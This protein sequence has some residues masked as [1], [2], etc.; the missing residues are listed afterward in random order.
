[1]D[2][3]IVAPYNKKRIDLVKNL[4]SKHK[5][6]LLSNSSRDNDK[7]VFSSEFARYFD[8][9]SLSHMNTEKKPSK[10][11]FLRL[12][13]DFNVYTEEVIFIDDK[14]KNVEGAKK[15]GIN[16]I[17]FENYKKLIDDLKKLD[18]GLS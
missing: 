15:L 10:K 17:L 9:I 18:V 11:A 2:D 13:E 1:M 14:S 6:V 5:L 8:R 12:L 4:T 16:N 3:N 7:A